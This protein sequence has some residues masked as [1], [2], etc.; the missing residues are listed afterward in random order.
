MWRL[1]QNSQN[2]N[3]EIKLNTFFDQMAIGSG[4]GLR[5]D[6]NYF[7][8]R[9]DVGVKV[10]DPQFLGSDQ[11]VISHFF[12]KQEFKNNYSKT[13]SPDSYN[14]LQWNFGIGMPF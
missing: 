12:R 5:L 11:W 1:K 14:F 13:N 4:L 3:G 7:V 9:V 6:V 2:P 8:I 10:K